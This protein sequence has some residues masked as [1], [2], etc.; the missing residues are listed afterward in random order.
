M[1]LFVGALGGQKRISD[2]PGVRGI[3]NCKLLNLF[4]E[5]NSSPLQEQQA[6]LTTEPS[7]QALLN[8]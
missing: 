6:L 3:G 1:S 8:V 5:T 4:W 2:A 7:A